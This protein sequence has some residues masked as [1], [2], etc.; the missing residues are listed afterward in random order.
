MNKLRAGCV[1]INTKT[2][3]KFL[4]LKVSYGRVQSA[5]S[6]EWG[7]QSRN[8]EDETMIYG[9]DGIFFNKR[10]LSEVNRIY[11]EMKEP[12]DSI[13]SFLEFINN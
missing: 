3:S 4:V 11:N 9:W 8:E 13:N 1:F 10:S 6:N 5:F 12:D 7:N 2:N